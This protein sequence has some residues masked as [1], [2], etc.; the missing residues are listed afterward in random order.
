M[1]LAAELHGTLIL[2][3]Q[4]MKQTASIV[5]PQ[6]QGPRFFDFIFRNQEN[7]RW[8]W[9]AL[10]LSIIGWCLFKWVYPN[11]N[12]VLDSYCLVRGAI[13]GANVE[14]WPIGYSK[15][16]IL[17]GYLSHS[18]MLLVWVQYM[19]M[20]LACMYF[21]FTLL[22]I[23][24]PGKWVKA[25]MFVFLFA[26]PLFYYI[27]NFVLTDGLYTTLSVA[28]F[29]LLIW[30]VFRPKDYMIWVH[31]L[32]LLV[33]F[34]IRY[35]AMFYPFIAA[36]AFL[37]SSFRLWKKLV[38]M[39]LA[40][41]MVLGFI[42]FTRNEMKQATG[43]SGFTVF[44]DWKILN[45]ALFGYGHFY[46]TDPRPVPVEFAPLDSLIRLSFDVNGPDDM[47]NYG[48]ITSGSMYMFHPY[49]P[50]T[51]YM[52]EQEQRST[53]FI[54][55][56]QSMPMSPLYGAYGKYLVRWHPFAFVRY[57]LLPN[58]QRHLLPPMESYASPSPFILHKDKVLGKPTADWFHLTTLECRSFGV[59]LRDMLLV[60]AMAL[61]GIIQVAFLIVV[62][63][64]L[65][66][67]LYKTQPP[68]SN[69]V[70]L[71][72]LLFTCA[73]F[74]FSVTSAGIV[75]RYLLLILAIELCFTLVVGEQLLKTDKIQKLLHQ[76]K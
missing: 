63:G 76:L 51:L 52:S 75:L 70:L 30:V 35:N 37:F 2:L 53:S 20:V 41:G 7:R 27:N 17:L 67:R 11:P 32:L 15:F 68:L 13:S 46:K 4:H 16:L 18:A 64:V 58:V 69:K 25:G 3:T 59:S 38:A 61:T 29:T 24:N 65:Y 62:V 54:I 50:L 47:Y 5:G 10:G 6:Q 73:E 43:V 9:A 39:V 42:V 36:A 55:L 8:C 33:L 1:R 72:V 31:A 56:D 26:N 19:G 40:G 23:F 60:P 21:F 34:S 22:Y 57:F 45:N 49:S 66:T 28:W 14:V 12:M 48:A 44:S 74:A 71:L